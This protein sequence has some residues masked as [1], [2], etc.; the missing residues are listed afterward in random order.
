MKKSLIYFGISIFVFIF[1]QI[2]EYFSHG[3]YSSYMMFA[4]LI[5]FIGLFIPSLLNNLILKR[6][7]TDNVTLPWKCGIA[8]LT[9]GSIYKGVLE[10]YGTSG[11]FEQVY[12]IIGSLLCIIATIVL[13]T[14]RVNKDQNC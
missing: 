5:P 11:T 6:K 7:I 1:G 4:F 3:V 12:L 13:I 9:V 8:T 10:I 14:A 2:Y